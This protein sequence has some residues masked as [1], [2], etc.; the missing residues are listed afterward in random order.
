MSQN[1]DER[2]ASL[3]GQASFNTT[4]WSVVLRAGAGD[5]E[6]ARE[7]LARLCQTYWY[8]LYAYARRK[9][10]SEHDAQ[11]LVQGFLAR[12][13]EKES[14]RR[15]TREGGRFRSYLLGA[16]NHFLADQRDFA[17]AA[18][19]GGGR[20]VVSLDA[21]AAEDRYE[22]EPVDDRSPE[23]LFE[24]RWAL[25]ILDS[26]LD[27]LDREYAMAG[28]LVLFRRLQSCLAGDP[29]QGSYAQIGRE[30]SLTEGA[31]KMAALRLRHRYREIIVEAIAETV[32]NPADLEDELRFL[33]SAVSR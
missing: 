7:A 16:F 4:R 11:D 20:E 25:T 32:G 9:G 29:D 3:G 15:V 8:P 6:E 2:A 12:L 31:V 33:Q 5:S 22:L 30:F 13:L 10:F 24:R 26:V 14:L 28:K 19:R 1:H 27:R 21:V 17:R 18:K 23:Q